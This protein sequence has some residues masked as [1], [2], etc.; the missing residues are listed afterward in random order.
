M[1]SEF[2]ITSKRKDANKNAV[3]ILEAAKKIFAQKGY[4]TTIEE[5]ALEANVGVGTV[6]RRFNNKHQ[7]AN[8]VANEVIS[9]IYEEQV[10]ILKSNQ[11]TVE[12]VKKVFACY[13]KITQK[14]GEIHPIIVDLLVSEKGEEEFK[15]TFLLGLKNLYAEVITNGQK[16][17]IFREGDPRLYEIYLQNMINPQIVKQ[18]AEIIPLEETP[19]FL[20]DL[21]LNGLLKKN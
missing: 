10:H 18:I 15:E 12:K 19:S 6:Y 14:Y 17:N 21:A 11:S 16:E 13:A 20:A 3:K 8:A 2:I 7:L 9:E 5:V 1:D 4:N